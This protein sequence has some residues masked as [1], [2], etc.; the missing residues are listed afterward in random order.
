MVLGRLQLEVL[1]TSFPITRNLLAI[2]YY[3]EKPTFRTISN[4]AGKYLEQQIKALSIELGVS[5][6]GP[7][8]DRNAIFD[9][10]SKLWNVQIIVYSSHHPPRLSAIFP[11]KWD[12]SIPQIFLYLTTGDEVAHDHLNLIKDFRQFFRL[13]GYCCPSCGHKSKNYKDWK[14]RCPVV[15]NCFVCHREILTKSTFVTSLNKSFFCDSEME[16]LQ[17]E[18]ETH[19]KRCNLLLKTRSCT[20]AHSVICTKKGYHC[21]KCFKFDSGLQK[22]MK[23]SHK[24]RT[25]H[26]CPFCKKI[27]EEDHLCLWQDPRILSEMPNLGFIHFSATSNSSKC[28]KCL[29]SEKN[30]KDKYCESHYFGPMTKSEA[31]MAM[32]LHEDESREKFS[33]VS[34][35]DPQFETTDKF[36]KHKFLLNYLPTEY[37]KKLS[38]KKNPGRF[39]NVIGRNM[40]LDEMIVRLDGKEEKTVTELLLSRLLQKNFTNYTFVVSSQLGMTFLLEALVENELAP[41]NIIY[42]DSITILIP[43]REF[44]ITFVCCKQFISVPFEEMILQFGLKDKVKLTYF[45]TCL[46]NRMHFNLDLDETPSLDNY[47]ELTDS[48]KLLQEKKKY[49]EENKGK[50]WNFKSSMQ[51]AIQ[52]EMEVLAKSAVSLLKTSFEFQQQLVGIFGLPHL[53]SSKDKPLLHLFSYPSLGGFVFTS[54]RTFVIPTLPE[55]SM[56]VVQNQFGE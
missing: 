20:K 4:T 27:R 31:M 13:R 17:K 40:H 26:R 7:H 14:H 33:L 3:L 16:N 11:S 19:C 24:C 5:D 28:V 6:K 47:V 22:L 46:S 52:S 51:L 32:L 37:S 39:G 25:C 56:Y 55:N 8:L 44:E 34:I 50:R 49:V 42:K 23:T 10:V 18:D 38:K 15:P 53:L 48:E 2:K 12:T 9:Q 36:E 43:I 35:F 45:P 41:Q 29:E 21:P 1:T 54:F 30:G